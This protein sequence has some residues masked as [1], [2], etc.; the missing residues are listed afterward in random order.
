[1]C[2]GRESRR[3]EAGLGA[4]LPL[5]ARAAASGWE[6]GGAHGP[7]VRGRRPRSG[8]LSPPHR[9]PSF[10]PSC[11]G[12][13]TG[14]STKT[15]WRTAFPAISPRASRA[16]QTTSTLPSPCPPRTT[17]PASAS[18][19]SKVPVAGEWKG[20]MPLGRVEGRRAPSPRPACLRKGVP[21]ATGAGV[22]PLDGARPVSRAELRRPC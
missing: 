1:M 14:A 20:L 19:S 22:S 13:A 11:R 5:R 9:P 18:T 6:G 4:P 7:S 12:A 21:G 15:S 8:T 2:A 17:S 10:L 16:F 3:S